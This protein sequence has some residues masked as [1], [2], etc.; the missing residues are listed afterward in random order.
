MPKVE[1]AFYVGRRLF[2]EQKEVVGLGVEAVITDHIEISVGDMDN[3]TLDE[4]EDGDSFLD[5]FIV[6]V[7][8]V[9]KGNG[10]IFIVE[11]SFLGDDGPADVTEEII[12]NV[13][14]IGDFGV[15]V[16]IEAV[17]FRGI[18]FVDDGIET[19]GI[20]IVFKVEEQGGH[21]SFSE[22]TER[23][24]IEFLKKVIG[25]LGA[26]GNEHMN[27][28]VPFQISAESMQRSDHAAD[29]AL[30]FVLIDKPL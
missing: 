3:D 18:Q 13:V 8:V 12:D 10:V 11:N 24:E 5:V 7:A 17:V 29:S 14:G 23:D 4:L 27:V 1:L 2:I 20:D 21:K 6:L 15:S 30:T 9:A 19:G 26:E 25:A 28:R 22:H 16:N